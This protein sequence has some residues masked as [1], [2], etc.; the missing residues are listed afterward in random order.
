MARNAPARSA[1]SGPGRFSRR[2]EKV[3]PIREPDIDN[4]DLQYGDRSMLTAAQRVARLPSGGQ[5]RQT[6]PSTGGEPAPGT[7]RK[8]PDFMFESPSAFPEQ[9][10]TAGLDMGAGP[11]SEIL[12]SRQQPPDVREQVLMYLGNGSYGGPP[13][14]EAQQ[15]LAQ[16]RNDRAAS[17][18]PP[19]R[20][21]PAIVP[22]TAP[23]AVAMG[24]PEEPQPVMPGSETPPPTEPPPEQALNANG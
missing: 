17:A 13:N 5:P 14:S 19:L 24:P 21:S 8:L 18:M 15:A 1:P 20:P 9:P 3:Q 16:L 11:G 23:G 2:D 7:Q 10:I 4:P 22:P 6:P 12:S